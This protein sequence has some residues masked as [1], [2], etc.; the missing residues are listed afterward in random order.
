MVRE[1]D[2]IFKRTHEKSGSVRVSCL[3][4][5]TGWLPTYEEV[6]TRLSEQ[7]RQKAPGWHG[8]QWETPPRV[9]E[10]VQLCVLSAEASPLSSL[11]PENAGS[12]AFA[13]AREQRPE[14]TD[15]R[16]FPS[17]TTLFAQGFQGF[18]PHATKNPQPSRKTSDIKHTAPPKSGGKDNSEGGNLCRKSKILIK[19]RLSVTSKK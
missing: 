5:T 16:G 19:C 14:N 9:A 1:R 15:G 10:L 2:D 8:W 12:H 17:Q 11:N 7:A 4:H 18:S 3:S 6:W 13:S